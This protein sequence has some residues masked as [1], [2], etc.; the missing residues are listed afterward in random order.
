MAKASDAKRTSKGIEYRGENYPG[1][2]KPKTN[3][4]SS[5]HKKVVLAK[6]GDEIK[7]VK[8]GHRD[9]GNHYSAETRKNY[10][11]RSAGIKTASGSATKDD[12]FSPNYWSRKVLW[13]GPSASKTNPK[14]GGPR[15]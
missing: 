4:S 10:L 11:A 5:K 13:G 3:T 15:K 2:N 1:F 8:F 12:K 9:Y 14:P 6:K 7:V